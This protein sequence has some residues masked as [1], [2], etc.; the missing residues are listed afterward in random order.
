M[1]N[2]MIPY[3]FIP[4]TKAKAGEV[5]ANFVSL[6][7]VIEQN[8]QT[9]ANDIQELNDVVAGKADS[10]DLTKDFIVNTASTDLNNYKTPGNYIFTSSYTP[11]N[12]PKGS[13]GVLSVL[14]TG[15]RIKQVWYSDGTIPDI[16]VRMYS[17]SSWSAWATNTTAKNASN[18][19]YVKMANGTIIQWGYTT[20]GSSG[21]SVTF[22]TSFTNTP[23]VCFGGRASSNS[24]YAVGALHTSRTTT[25]FTAHGWKVSGTSD[26]TCSWIA[27]GY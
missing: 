25:G 9:A 5:N 12:I 27:I 14:G 1:T 13:S 3:S 22:P 19:G 18:L 6:A 17:G 16:Y 23:Q 24:I 7:D 8:R 20:F 26:A 21:T 10:E 4:G 15:S 2:S 11:T